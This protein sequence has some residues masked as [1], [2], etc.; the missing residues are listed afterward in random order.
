MHKYGV[1]IGTCGSAPIVDLNINNI[2]HLLGNVPILIND[3]AS[4]TEFST[5]ARKQKCSLHVNSKHYG[6]VIGDLTAFANGLEWAIDNK[7]KILIK[8]SR[9]LLFRCDIRKH[10]EKVAKVNPKFECISANYYNFGYITSLFVMHTERFSHKHLGAIKQSIK[11][12]TY[13]IEYESHKRRL[14]VDGLYTRHTQKMNQELYFRHCLKVNPILLNWWQ[15]RLF[16]WGGLRHLS[17]RNETFTNLPYTFE[18]LTMKGQ[19]MIHHK[20][21]EIYKALS[22]KYGLSYSKNELSL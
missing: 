9:K 20:S 10:I 18:N 11:T 19:F 15:H 8:V 1:V 2:K 21:L 22:V 4:G 16:V 13:P 14:I 7:I 5:I 3:D 6:H 12:E 17:L